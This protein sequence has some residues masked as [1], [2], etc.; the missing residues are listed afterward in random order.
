[1]PRN[2]AEVK[3]PLK[4]ARISTFFIELNTA[5]SL[6]ILIFVFL[7]LYLL[8]MLLCKKYLCV[9]TSH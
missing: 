6:Y 7:D 9:L 5:L 3:N 8:P 1:M 4:L 2:K